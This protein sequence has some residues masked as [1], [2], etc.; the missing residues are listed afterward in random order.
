MTDRDNDSRARPAPPRRRLALVLLLVGA[1]GIALAPILVRLS[2]AGPT[3]TAAWRI[4]IALPVLALFA[5]FEARRGVAPAGGGDHRLLIAAGLF[6]AADLAVWHAAL[7]LTSIANATFFANLSPIGVAVGA[8]LLLGERPTGAFLAGLALALAGSAL[9]VVGRIDGV[10]GGPQAGLGDTLAMTAAAF[11]A[12]YLLAVKS[13]RVR[14][15]SGAILFWSG[16]ASL[17]LLL[18]LAWAL[19]ESFW[20]QSWRGWLAVGLLGLFS[21]AAGQGLIAWALRHLPASFSAVA[22]LLQPVVSTLIAWPILGE[23]VGFAQ[24]GGGAII[25]IGVYLARPA[26]K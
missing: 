16:L 13:L 5:G 25:L 7:G 10:G 23:A 6:F 8:W 11:Y 26:P 12:G 15:G 9:L 19:D 18:P 24:A 20:P 3:A 4:L 21:H 17:A 22:L 1:L 2:E 14:L